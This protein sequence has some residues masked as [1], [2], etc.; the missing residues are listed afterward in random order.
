MTTFRALLPPLALCALAACAGGSSSGAPAPA[1]EPAVRNIILMIADGTGAG[2]WT[3]AE[4]ASD[5]LNV[6]RMPVTGLVDTRS[7][8]H[9][10]T[11]S[12]AGATVYA[13]GE[14]VTNRT[15]SVGPSSA[16]PLPRGGNAAGGVWPAGCERLE[17]WFAIARSKGKATGVTTT[18][19]VVDATPAAFVAHSPSRYWSEPIA[20][21]FA[22]AGLDVL[23]GGG[24]ASFEGATRSD[25]RDL[26]GAM[27]AR[28]Q[29][30][31]D[32]GELA[33]YRPDARPL[34]GL[35]TPGDMDADS[36]RAV[37]VPAMVEAALAKLSRDPDGFVAMFE[38][39]ATDNA[40][41]SNL[42]LERVTADILEFDRAVGIA[43]DF[44]RR[45]PGTLLIVTSDHETGGFSLA[46]TGRDFELKY[47]TRGHTG[48]LVPL[49]A[50]GPFAERF[51]GFRENHEIGRMLVEIVRGW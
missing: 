25:G 40:T 2:V 10:V 43:L 34:V 32:A 16:C 27:C 30:V 41:H 48:A 11:D 47:T 35:F 50:Y 38:T 46:E 19:S 26:L 31:D 44:A 5:A 20:A 14:R 24:R 36:T 28:A 7:A 37:S 51:G 18:T 42:P 15:I 9:K 4:F 22:E 45:T 29:C 8:S 21:Q 17:T 13:T 3:A 12:A 23:L 6:K 33:A 39:E 1:E 49:F